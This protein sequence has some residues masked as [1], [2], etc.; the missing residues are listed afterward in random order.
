[1]EVLG[2]GIEL[3][4]ISLPV[5][6]FILFMQK[7]SVGE[8]FIGK[9]MKRNEDTKLVAG[10][11]FY[12]GDVSLP[13][14]LYGAVFRSPLPHIRVKSIDTSRAERLPGVVAVY[15]SSSLGKLAG[16]LPPSVSPLPTYP[17]KPKTHYAL[18]VDKA[19][20]VGE[21][22]A[23]IVAESP[24]IA[25]DALEYIEVEYETLEPVVD[26]EEAT[27]PEAA[28]VHEDMPNNI[29]AEHVSE[30]GDYESALSE[31][32]L[33]VREK[34]IYNRGG[35]QSIETRGVV[36]SF[37]TRTETLTVWDSTQAPIPIRNGLASLFN[38]PESNVRVIAPDVGGGFGPKI[39][40]FYPEE[41]LIPFAAIQLK[42]PVKWI[43]DRREYSIAANQE[44]I[45]VH[46][47]EAAFDPEGRILG[48]KDD[49]LVDTGAYTPYGVMIPIITMCTMPGPYRIRNMWFRFRSVF[50][51]K[52]I[53]TP[54]RGAGRPQAVFVMERLMDIAAGK[55]GMGRAAIRRINLIK[56]E[57]MPWDTGLIYQDGAPNEYDSGNYPA[58][59]ERL[60]EISGFSD[61]RKPEKR[62]GERI[63]LGI[64]LYVEGSGVGPY[65]MAK[66]KIDFGGRVSVITGVGSQGQGHF[67]VL[68]QVAAEVLG[69]DPESI[70]VTVGDTA[71]M[72]WGVGTFASRSA[73]VAAPAV[74]NAAVK[75]REK[76]IKLASKLL[77]INPED[78]EMSGGRVYVKDRPDIGFN[79]AELAQ[80][81]APLRGTIEEDPGL[82]ATAFF[83]PKGS[84]FS[85]GACVAEVSV[86]GET[87]KVT[88][89]RL[90]LVHDCGRI[91]NPLIVEGQIHGGVAMGLGSTLLEEI[92]YDETG[93]P[94]ATTFMDYLIPSA[95]D[96]PSETK[97]DHMETP[98]PKN[99]LGAKGVGE[100]GVI[101]I[102]AAVASAVDDAL[103]DLGIFIREIPVKPDKLWMQI[104]QQT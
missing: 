87:G 45:Q 15:T 31:A 66:V 91:I 17:V 90:W 32:S 44:R 74:Y 80:K 9:S 19:R 84:V 59:L 24:Y 48:L 12:V 97:I 63:G 96:M 36:A 40:L 89:R 92:I 101:P 51:T 56:P 98:T 20:Y 79:L 30:V 54:V 50:T 46:Y 5:E 64:A 102:A 10:R 26:V 8:K 61:Q 18:V 99:P 85:S 70:S 38:L 33:V 43:E 22:I 60:L 100:A 7:V 2:W 53:V 49:F 39:M 11:G 23:F 47:A 13:G 104:K 25:R 41:I 1:M 75:V 69:V 62:N 4:Y 3:R 82:E 42:R 73:A 94:L 28:L 67:T 16:P 93:Q 71:K 21:P 88:L 37:D 55:L 65:E 57:E 27:K 83:S 76:A 86:D 14:M 29:A 68:A 81:S 95:T 72:E 35:G 77:E 52:N 103:S 6:E 58:L 78:L 34:F